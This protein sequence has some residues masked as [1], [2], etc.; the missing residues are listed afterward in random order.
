MQ[1]ELK[2]LWQERFH[3]PSPSIDLFFA[4]HFHPDNCAVYMVDEK[5]AAMAHML[6]AEIATNQ[7][8]VK[9]HYIYAAATGSAHQGKGCMRALLEYADGL[10]RERGHAYSFLLPSSPS[11]Y[12]FYA[13]LGYSTFFTMRFLTLTRDQLSHVT[14]GRVGYP[15][16]PSYAE[17]V[18]VRNEQVRH[19]PGSI[20]WGE[21]ALSY[22]TKL[23]RLYKG[24]L[25]C[26]GTGGKQ[27]YALCSQVSDGRCE[28]IEIM[29]EDDTLPQLAAS[30][31]RDVPAK[32]YR[33]RLP[34]FSTLFGGQGELHPW[35]MV[36]PLE[37]DI[38]AEMAQKTTAPY[39]G[40]TLD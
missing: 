8:F 1:D 2:A 13:R 26:A 27:A 29:A 17:L 23:T 21:K 40:L 28:V 39:L 15:L 38:F 24:E 14:R 31:L 33:L 11:L 25:I 19:H 5:V 16:S 22:A 18:A 32:H 37:R 20:L 10:G 12:D 34:A 7:G 30:I 36:K 9:G 3:E 35:G 4:E 6:P